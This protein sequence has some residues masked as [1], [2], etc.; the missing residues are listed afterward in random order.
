[1]G[2]WGALQDVPQVDLARAELF[3]RGR[4]VLTV[5]FGDDLFGR[6]G[7]RWLSQPGLLEML[8]GE[9]R[10]FPGFR[11]LRGVTAQALI[12][13]GGRCRGV[14][15]RG[16]DGEREIRADLVVGADGRASMVRRRAGLPVRQDPTVM[17]VVWL[18]LPLPP[19]MVDPPRVRAYAGNG[20][21]LI[22]SP[23]YDG[24]LQIGWVIRK[25]TFGE[26]RKR[27]MPE[28]IDAMGDHVSPEF[29]EHL[30]RHREDGIQPF[31]LSTVSDRVERWSRPGLLVIGDAAHTMS[32]V[33]AQGLNTA[34]RDA[35]V[36]ANHLVPVLEGGAAPE[37]LDRAAA[38]VEAERRHEV[39]VTQ[40]AQRLAPYVVLRDG[41]ANRLFYGLV[42]RMA[43]NDAPPPPSPGVS[44]RFRRVAAGVDEVRLRV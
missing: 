4:P 40:R 23:S 3:V 18:K 12:E 24:R 33:G 36:A 2:L 43:G 17:D 5:S 42:V 25:G 21:L 22:A 35:L 27:G 8:V 15:V 13:E 20:H 7:P 11:L 16:N 29:A 26:I 41:L 38:A 37:A 6:F 39:A 31:L 10:R 28:C 30:V 19:F 9:A 44:R 14:R 32:P 1:M 34:I